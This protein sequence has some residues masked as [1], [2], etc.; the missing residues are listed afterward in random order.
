MVGKICFENK[1]SSQQNEF[2]VSE[3]KTGNY[4]VELESRGEVYRTKLIKN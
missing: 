3:L 1:F 2:I 4:I